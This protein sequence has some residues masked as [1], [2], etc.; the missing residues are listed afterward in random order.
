MGYACVR[1]GA[2]GMKISKVIEKVDEWQPNVFSTEAKLDWCYE[3]ARAILNACP[4]YGTHEVDVTAD[5]MV[6]PLP[7]GV[8]LFD[9]AELYVNR[10]R[11]PITNATDYND[12]TFKKGDKVA[13]VYRKK[14]EV[15][16]LDADGSV[17]ESLETVCEAPYESMYIDF[18]CAQIA[19]QQNDAAEYNKFMGMFNDKFNGYKLFYG[20]NAPSG[21]A[22]QFE[23]WF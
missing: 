1:K 6:I 10:V 17:P 8:S 13:I 3:C 18:V 5:S 11:M 21:V 23:N 20:S 16:Q 12:Y 14:P 19:F 9:I 22:K 7:L 2:D 15:Y 4:V